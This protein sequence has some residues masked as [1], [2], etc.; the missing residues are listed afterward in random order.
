MSDTPR[1]DREVEDARNVALDFDL[2]T[3]R[4]KSDENIHVVS[5]DFAR[6]LERE[7]NELNNDLKRLKRH[8]LMNYFTEVNAEKATLGPN[9]LYQQVVDFLNSIKT[10]TKDQ[11]NPAL[12]IFHL[13]SKQLLKELGQY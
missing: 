5:V 6:Q 2:R 3:P 11:S 7:L 12:V 4:P 8:V 9:E 1:T 13:K 10:T